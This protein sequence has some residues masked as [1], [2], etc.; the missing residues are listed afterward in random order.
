MRVVVVRQP[1]EDVLLVGQEMQAA[2][3]ERHLGMTVAR[4]HVC[5]AVGV[6]LL[7]RQFVLNAHVVTS[8][9]TLTLP[10]RIVVTTPDG[11]TISRS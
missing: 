11:L 7:D 8:L 6:K 4:R 10:L 5:L 3:V 1:D 9:L 2:P